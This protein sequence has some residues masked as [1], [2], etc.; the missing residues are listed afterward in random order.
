MQVQFRHPGVL[1]D[2]SCHCNN[3]S[4][5]ISLAGL[6]VMSKLQSKLKNLPPSLV[7]KPCDIE[8]SR[9]FKNVDEGVKVRVSVSDIEVHLAATTVHTVMDLIDEVSM[10]LNVPDEEKLY[11][12]NVYNFKPEKC[13]EDLWSPKK[14]TPYVV[15][16]PDDSYVTPKYPVVNAAETFYMA[17]P[18]VRVIFELESSERVPV[19]MVKMIS[20]VNLNDWSKQ[21]HGT[22][23]LSIHAACY[24]EKV[25]SWEPLIEPTLINENQHR[26]WEITASLF[27]AKAYPMSSRLDTATHEAESQP[28]PD[29]KKKKK[30][31]EFESETSA[32]ECD[33]DNE[34]VIIRNP[35]GRES[36]TVEL[37]AGGMAFLTALDG[38]DSDSENENGLMDKLATAIGHLFTDDS[39]AEELS[40][41]EDSSAPEQSEVE[42][43]R[44]D[45]DKNVTFI[46]GLPS[47]AKKDGEPKTV[48]LQDP[49]RE[50]SIDSG[51]ETD[52][53]AERLCTYVMLEA[54]DML[55]VTVT[56]AA[57]RVLLALAS[58]CTDSTAAV[59]AIVIGD[60][61]L[62]LINDIGPGSTVHLKTKAE[63]DLAGNDKI[64]A[65]ADYDVDTSRPSTPGCDTSSADL[66]DDAKEAR[67]E[68]ADVS[69]DWD[70]CFEGGFPARAMS[71]PP[72]LAPCSPLAPPP[73]NDLYRRYTD[74]TLTVK[75]HDFDQLTILCPQ[76]TVSKLH[77]L[78]PS[79]NN[80]RY[81]IVVD[82]TSKFSTRKI[83][84]RS[85]LQVRNETSYAL[86]LYYKK[87]D[88]QAIGAELIG[89]VSNPFDDKMRLAV[90]A[91]QDTYNV[92][93]YIAYHCKLFLLPSNNENYTTA[94]QG[95]WW[96]E[97]AND[98][99]TPR[100]LICPAKAP[101][102]NRIF[103]MRILTEEGCQSNKVTR[104]IPNYLIRVVPP[105]AVYNRLPYGMELSCAQ[106]EWQ[107][108]VEAGER[109]HT[110]T[111]Q[112]CANHRLTLD[113]HYM[114][115]PWTGSFTLSPDLTEK[116]ISMTTD[117]ET[118]GGNKQLGV[119]VRVERADCWQLYVYAPYWLINKTGLPLQMKA[120]HSETCYEVT[121]EPLL[122]A[123]G[124]RARGCERIRLRAH[125][126]QWSRACR[127][128]A[129]APGLVVCAHTE[130]RTSY[131]LLMDVTL[132]ELCPQLTKIVTLLPYFLVYNDTR[133]HLRFMEENEAADLWID[134]APQ[135]C[136]PFWPQTDSMSMHCKYR[137][138]AVVSQHFPITKN[139]FTVLR[140]DKGVN[141]K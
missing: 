5:V 123:C 52:S 11:T 9:I 92:P 112:L 81:Y 37:N 38:D 109:T 108:R 24:N 33:T 124:S 49:I 58:A 105:L 85:P 139:H 41:D 13:D 96:M 18:N 116:N 121:D 97:L 106:A 30:G 65:I 34:M 114:G 75:L 136:T 128:A 53:F 95:I 46:D 20:E 31:N 42:S 87:T 69:E 29:N 71:P 40:N 115:L 111:L 51:L 135:Q 83:V 134:L 39:S 68:M 91:P 78:H 55:N 141:S 50:D 17:L 119:C 10:E 127:P 74:E 89:C 131:R 16:N 102:D 63:T 59:S 79:R 140:M 57:A 28:A 129:A 7:L 138:S 133:R 118:D 32:D 4:L 36:K 70:C 48:T 27:Q 35:N 107:V 77:V 100:D 19:L 2:Y 26:P 8:F 67:Y 120:R 125:Q 113:M 110:Y 21:L 90:I 72:A 82:R 56:P 76:R 98:L 122:W 60:S 130:R 25:G 22:A 64:L 44:E 3:D 94:T 93:M 23:S 47:K 137:D 88:L 6:Q 132:S 45:N 61:P 43:E 54:K 84:V 14:I 73:V 126:S 66:L 99:G 15:L 86:E 80:T 104:A 1:V 62:Q 101:D 12:T 117:C 103:A